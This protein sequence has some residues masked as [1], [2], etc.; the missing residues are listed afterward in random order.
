MFDA[1]P[2]RLLVFKLVVDLGGFSAAA[3]HLGIAQPSVGAH[4]DAL[5]QRAG[6]SLLLRRRGARPQL[7]DAGRI[8]YQLASD[9]QRLNEDAARRIEDLRSGKSA[10]LR[11]AAHRDLATYYMPQRLARFT[12]AN[13]RVRIVTRIGTIEDVL[14]LLQSG[15][16]QIALLLSNGPLSGMSSEMVGEQS[17]LIV[18]SPGH[19]LARRTRVGPAQLQKAPFVTGLKTSRYFAMVESALATIGVRRCDVAIELQ[20]STA[21]KEIARSGQCIACLPRCT[22]DDDLRSGTLVELRLEQAL[23]AL[24]IRCAHVAPLVPLTRRLVRALRQG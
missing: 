6:E 23:P 13:P 15:A 9:M 3:A 8:V 2:R 22:V 11:I 7:T 19:P 17:L 21:V 20:E 14:G 5:E 16:A 18:A 4:I 24:Q 10:E 12:R 1:T